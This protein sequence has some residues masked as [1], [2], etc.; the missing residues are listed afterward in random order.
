MTDHMEEARK[1]MQKHDDNIYRSAGFCADIAAALSAAEQRERERCAKIAEDS[2]PMGQ[3]M[4]YE[5]LHELSSRIAAHIKESGWSLYPIFS[6]SRLGVPKV[7]DLL[8]QILTAMERCEHE[9]GFDRE[10]GPIGCMLGD[11]CVC[12]GIY[13]RVKAALSL[14]ES[15]PQPFEEQSY[16]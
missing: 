2:A 1:L 5:A 9:G 11:R 14:L 16:D 3:D 4:A 13:P 15:A 6:T 12:L 8:A 7:K 10:I